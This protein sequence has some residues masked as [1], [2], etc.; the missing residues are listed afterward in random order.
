MNQDDWAEIAST[1]PLDMG[2]MDELVKQSVEAWEKSDELKKI[3]TE[4]YHLAEAIDSKILNALQGAGKTKYFVDGY[5]T[6]SVCKKLVV[7][8]PNS[9]EEKKKFFTFLNEIGEEVFFSL[10]T[11]NSNSLNAWYNSRLDEAEARGF[12]GFLV[13]GIDQPVTRE[14]LRFNKDRK[15]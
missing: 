6:M 1:K 15:K 3:A 13:P 14:T 2:E 12:Q 8:V 9:I 5:G 10:A 4:A 7:R 11:V